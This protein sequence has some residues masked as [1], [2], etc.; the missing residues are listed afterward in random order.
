MFF[1]ADK[2]GNWWGLIRENKL[3]ALLL[4]VVVAGLTINMRHQQHGASRGKETDQLVICNLDTYRSITPD[5]GSIELIP[6]Y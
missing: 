1:T 6:D 3:R 2:A 4:V 5:S